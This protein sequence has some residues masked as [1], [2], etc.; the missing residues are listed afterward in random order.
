MNDD[1][2][3]NTAPYGRAAEA[4]AMFLDWTLARSFCAQRTFPAFSSGKVA[5]LL[6]TEPCLSRGPGGLLAVIS[7][8]RRP[9]QQN[10]ACRLWERACGDSPSKLYQQS[11]DPRS[12]LT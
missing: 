5:R 7:P 8:H 6:P 10:S 3:R 9:R 2:S 1:D 11:E 4:I 12:S